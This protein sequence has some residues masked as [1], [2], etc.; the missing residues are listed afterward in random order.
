MTCEVVVELFQIRILVVLEVSKCDFQFVRACAELIRTGTGNNPP[1][2][3]LDSPANSTTKY[4][5][6]KQGCPNPHATK[7]SS[8]RTQHHTRPRNRWMILADLELTD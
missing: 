1:T 3:A 8:R 5:T 4:A 6:K 2:H 7:S